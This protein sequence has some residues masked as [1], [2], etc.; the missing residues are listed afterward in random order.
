MRALGERLTARARMIAFQHLSSACRLFSD[1]SEVLR[2]SI[3]ERGRRWMEALRGGGLGERPLAAAAFRISL[4]A[5]NLRSTRCV[6]PSVGTFEVLGIRSGHWALDLLRADIGV[7]CALSGRPT[8]SSHP[9]SSRP[10][11]SAILPP[12]GDPSGGGCPV[13][14]VVCALDGSDQTAMQHAMTRVTVVA[15]R[16]SCKTARGSVQQ[17]RGP[18]RSCPCLPAMMSPRPPPLC[19]G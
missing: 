2:A 13:S 1:G 9:P 4:A 18:E 14:H 16:Y 11:P 12:L 19:Q 5:A 7:L 8:F 10:R 6:T 15:R 3:G 17:P